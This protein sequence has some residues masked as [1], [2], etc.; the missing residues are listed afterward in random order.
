M[1]EAET[2]VEV[3]RRAKLKLVVNCMLMTGSFLITNKKTIEG[4]VCCVVG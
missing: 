3:A 4:K 1:I 2:R